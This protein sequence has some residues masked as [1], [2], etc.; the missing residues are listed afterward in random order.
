MNKINMEDITK[1]IENSKVRVGTA[2]EVV[3]VIST[4]LGKEEEE[5]IKE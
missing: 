2:R 1:L 4:T 3:G 5:Q